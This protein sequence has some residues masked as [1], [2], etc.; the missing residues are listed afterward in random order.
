MY[1]PMSFVT[2]PFLASASIPLIISTSISAFFLFA[3]LSTHSEEGRQRVW[4]SALGALFLTCM[5]SP[6]NLLLGILLLIAASSMPTTVKR[7]TRSRVGVVITAVVYF[8]AAIP[9]TR[10]LLYRL[11]VR[12]RYPVE[13]L[14]DRLDYEQAVLRDSSSVFASANSAAGVTSEAVATRLLLSGKRP[15][16]SYRTHELQRLH[17]RELDGFVFAVG[18]GIGRMP[19]Y[20]RTE[21]SLLEYQDEPGTLT[22]ADEKSFLVIDGQTVRSTA[23]VVEQNAAASTA[24]KQ[25]WLLGLHDEGASLFVNPASLGYV[26]GKQRA[27]GF[28][29][30]RFTIGQLPKWKADSSAGWAIARL[31]LV[32]LLKHKEPRVYIS[33]ELPQMD[34]LK[35]VPT[36]KL[37]EFEW[38]AL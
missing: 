29:S 27:A 10:G 26:A 4:R 2:F 20:P 37:N 38:H 5:L 31:E 13:S 21:E 14:A 19:F 6:V 25:E 28:V 35:S 18:F 36:R 8:L 11:Q 32:S 16:E 24:P 12:E 30:H 3:F 1:T 34:R 23:P 22:S 17:Q 9:G 15:W 33:A 7:S